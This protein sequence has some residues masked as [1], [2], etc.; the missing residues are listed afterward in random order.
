VACRA[1]RTEGGYRV[2]GTKSWI[3]HG[4]KADL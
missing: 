1:E 4:G 2:T 3:T